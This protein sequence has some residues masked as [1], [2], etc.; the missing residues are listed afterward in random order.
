MASQIKKV[1][2]LK[3]K[4]LERNNI[5]SLEKGSNNRVTVDAVVYH[6]KVSE[7]KKKSKFLTL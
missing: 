7:P 5:E 2:T 4:E 3:F 6:L 1:G